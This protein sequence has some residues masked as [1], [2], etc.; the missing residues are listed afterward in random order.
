MA[1]VEETTMKVQRL[2]TGPIGLRVELGDDYI[3]VKIGSSVSTMARISVHDFRSKDADDP[4]PVV[5][6]EAPILFD[7]KATPDLFEWI[8]REG[9]NSWFGHV[10]AFDGNEP[11]TV[12][13]NM[14]HTLLGDYLDEEELSYALFGVLSVA[15]KLD[16]ELQQRFGGQRYADR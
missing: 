11:G 1:T 14:S 6:I 13:L 12:F 2:L 5:V 16:D 8:A 10:R 15:D 3:W 7:V 9:G 4:E